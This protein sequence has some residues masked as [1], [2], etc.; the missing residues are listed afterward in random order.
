[1]MFDS[2]NIQSPLY[3][4]CV[5]RFP[6]DNEA[7]IQVENI[8]T[9]FPDWVKNYVFQETDENSI[10]FRVIFYSFSNCLS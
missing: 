3:Y 8:D 7:E 1:M 9:F 10:Q 6:N 4:L 5:N 2:G